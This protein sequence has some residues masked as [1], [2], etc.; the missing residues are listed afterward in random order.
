MKLLNWIVGAAL[1]AMTGTASADTFPSKPITLIVP[2]AAGGNVDVSTRILQKALGDS[3]G[4]PVVVENRPGGGGMIA[5]SYV[6]RSAP[7]GYTIFVASNGPLLF[8]PMNSDNPQYKWSEDF[9]PISTLSFA[10]NMM[11]VRASFPADTV[12]EFVAYAKENPGEIRVGISS[13]VSINHYIGLLLRRT[14]GIE[15]TEV[16]Y[17]GNAPAVTDLV[18]EQI[19]AGFQQL[20]DSLQH[21]Q[22]GR[23]KALAIAGTD[24]VDVLPDVP[25][26][27]EAGFA[28]VEGVTFNGLLAPKGTPQE[29]IDLL[30]AKVQEALKSEEAIQQFA[31]LGSQARGS[32]PADFAAFL[33]SE[34][35][36]WTDIVM[37]AKKAA[38]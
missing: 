12:E 17:N 4:Q 25:T 36:K 23:L 35:G 18:G 21:I 32:S 10:S 15:W 22:S 13:L 34:E 8:G 30:S 3:L 16:H 37:E 33:Q 14:A 27:A 19:D 38:N 2:Y 24:R 9:E 31:Q 29:I 1:A 6:A 26:M 7:D 11:L 28:G 5:G 20:V